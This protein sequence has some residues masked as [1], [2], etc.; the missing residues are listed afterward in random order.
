MSSDPARAPS[1]FRR[2][3]R[4]LRRKRVW[5]PLAVIAAAPLV[6]QACVLTPPAPGSVTLADRLAAFPA[7]AAPLHAPAEVRWNEHAVPYLIVEDERDLPFLMGMVHGHLRRAQ[8]EI[9]LRIAQG[10]LSELAGPVARDVDALLRTL[11]LDRAVPAMEAALPTETRAWC[12]RYVAGVN[13]QAARQSGRPH[14]AWLLGLDLQRRFTV[15]DVLT[16]GRLASVDISL[17]RTLSLLGLR[18]EAGFAEHLTRLEGV[19]EEGIASFGP[20]QPTPLGR[21]AEL[22]RS[23]SNCFVVAPERS[24]TG[25]AL[26]ASDPH[27]GFFLPN[28]WCLI[29]YATPEHRVV[30]LTLPGVPAVALGRNEHIAWG[31]TNM[32]AYS[33][34][35]YDVSGVADADRTVRR[36]RI[37]TRWWPDRTIDVVETPHG[38]VIS[39]LELF[40]SL[41]LPP[42]AWRWRGH[43][44]SDE[45]TAFVRASH[46]ENWGEFRAAWKSYAVAGQNMLYADVD[47]HIG[48]LLAL[49]QV[50]AAAEAGAALVADPADP[51]FRWSDGLDST[52]LPTALDPARGYL[53]SANNH[54]LRTEPPITAGGNAND[55]VQRMATRIEDGGALDLDAL[56]SIQRDVL[57]PSARALAEELVRASEG[58]GVEAP[59]RR[60]AAGTGMEAAPSKHDRSVEAASRLR[61][62]VAEWD[63]RFAADSRGAPAYVAWVEALLDGPYRKRMGDALTSAWRGSTAVHDRI[64]ADLAAGWP[65]REQVREA[66]SAAAADFDF[67]RPWGEV[68]RIPLRHPLGAAPWIGDAWTFDHLPGAGAFGTVRKTAGPLTAEPHLSTFGA[69]ARHVSDLGDPDANWFVLLGGQDGWIGSANLID[70]T[71]L[72]QDGRMIRMPLR[73]ATIEAE[74]P[75]VSRLDAEDR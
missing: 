39:D 21:L 24:A 64:R 47:G 55:R 28:F 73:Q 35:L 69:Q 32:V 56:R 68:R 8:M 70:Q 11:D 43:A 46:A 2:F 7:G 59:T 65:T 12:E 63:G 41:D 37:R 15:A 18:D 9:L 17:G 54:P 74:F 61:A 31:G 72:W 3:V 60:D 42:L 14:D 62:R 58:F 22:G 71:A 67:E 36:E 53:I 66:L 13:F 40:A 75:H 5:M 1:R 48:Q 6:L 49:E 57:L 38:P 16:I 34:A 4:R 27:L 33:S 25:S 26:L 23:G 10:R 50:P 29:G 52:E 19:E 30:G 45:L 20:G 51:R 44:A